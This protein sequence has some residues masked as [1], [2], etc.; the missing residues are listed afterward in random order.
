MRP[1]ELPVPRC[2]FLLIYMGLVV[3]FGKDSVLQVLKRARVAL[4]IPLLDFGGRI[5]LF[6]LVFRGGTATENKE[7]VC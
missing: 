6:L 5:R 1:P 3:R 2:F 7:G 4:I